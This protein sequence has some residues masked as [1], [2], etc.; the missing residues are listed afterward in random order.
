MFGVFDENVLQI[1]L[2]ELHFGETEGILLAEPLT[3]HVKVPIQKNLLQF[4]DLHGPILP[5]VNFQELH[6]VKFTFEGHFLT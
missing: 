4:F 2:F 3:E 1:G 5:N 6:G